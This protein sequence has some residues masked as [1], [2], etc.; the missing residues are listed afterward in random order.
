MPWFGSMKR[1]TLICI[2][3]PKG[4]PNRGV[5]NHASPLLYTG[6]PPSRHKYLKTKKPRKE[7]GQ[8]EK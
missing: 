6:I 4:K 7:H 8:G 3:L 5:N 1:D 2:S